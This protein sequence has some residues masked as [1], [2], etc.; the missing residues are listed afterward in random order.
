MKVIIIAIVALFATIIISATII[1]ISPLIALILIINML[2]NG[3]KISLFPTQPIK[4]SFSFKDN[5]INQKFK[6]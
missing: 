3:G 6:L 2:Y 5:P 4:K 1:I